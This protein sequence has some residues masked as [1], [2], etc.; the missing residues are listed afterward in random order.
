M[1]VEE[2]YRGQAIFS[3]P[4]FMILLVRLTV[5]VQSIM[6]ATEIL[7]SSFFRG[8]SGETPIFRGFSDSGICA[9]FLGIPGSLWVA[10]V[11]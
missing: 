10:E 6:G 4:K 3:I 2:S 7:R 11:T 1:H 8:K 5:S 9:L